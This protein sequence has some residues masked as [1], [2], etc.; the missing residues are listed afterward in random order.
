MTLLTACHE[1]E[2]AIEAGTRILSLEPLHEAAAHRLMRLYAENGRRGLAIQ[3][4]RALAGVLKT[5]L[6]TEPEAETRAAFAEIV[7]GS[8][9]RAAAPGLPPLAAAQAVTSLE[10]LQ[11]AAEPYALPSM[12]ARYPAPAQG[13]RA[14]IMMRWLRWI[15]AGAV[16]AA[17]AVFAVFHFT[18]SSPPAGPIPVAVLPFTNLSGDTA[19]EFFSDGITEEVTAAF[20]KVPGLQV[21]ARASA[22]QFKGQK[23]DMRAVGQA[24]GARYV[25]DGSVRAAGKHV[26][27]TAQLI[28]TDN[29]LSLWSDSYDRELTDVFAIQE[30]IARA[31][32]ASLRTPLGLKPDQNLVKIRDID[33]D[34]YLQFLR[35]RALV[36][37]RD[38]I[39][40]EHALPDAMALLEPIVTRYPD[41]APAWAQLALIYERMPIYLR[42]A[43]NTPL[44]VRRSASDTWLA[45]A[46]AASERAI[47]L[48]PTAA[49]GYSSLG[50]TMAMR[51][52]LLRADE[53]FSKALA[54]DPFYP[55][56]LHSYTN[57][58]SAVGYH[59]EALATREKLVGI[60]PFVPVYHSNLNDSAG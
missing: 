50:L 8:E 2:H 28:Q 3:L 16:A 14:R 42:N 20:A 5:E 40:L 55:E 12:P 44:E 15:G 30:D 35:A 54:L 26:R 56:A 45:K 4:Y 23:K 27:I 41:Y 13:V 19:Q 21:V 22:F 1:T 53:L 32:T 57:L 10:N 46:E 11:P 25:I 18:A 29:G 39:A 36:R 38:A 43:E 51:G 52:R 59:K 33:T 34:S 7:R 6:G 17:I 58:L 31:I 48:D 37:I 47:A 60:E 9:E 49:D 24:L